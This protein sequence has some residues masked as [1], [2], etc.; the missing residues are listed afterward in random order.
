[1]W[2]LTVKDDRSATLTCEDGNGEK[3][4]RKKIDVTDFPLPDITLW[5]TDRT[6]FLPSE[7]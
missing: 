1:V 3:V 4:F 5:F 7:Y 2:K 6:I